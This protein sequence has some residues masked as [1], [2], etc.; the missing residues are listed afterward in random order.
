MSLNPSF[1]GFGSY[2]AQ[3]HHVTVRMLALPLTCLVLAATTPA[4]G[5]VY[6]WADENGVTHYSSAPPG[7]TKATFKRMDSEALA[8]SQAKTPKQ[9]AP[10][11][12]KEQAVQDLNSK[13]DALEHQIDAEHQARQAA[14]AQNLAT[15]AAYA[16]ALADQ[17]VQA[18]RNV[19]YVSTIPATIPVVSG[20][21]LV[22]PS[23][24]MHHDSCRSM[25]AGTMTNCSSSGHWL[26]PSQNQS[27]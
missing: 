24:R 26:R 21:L 17:Q 1:A 15:Q 7:K 23:Q 6:K 19:G 5:Q 9:E 27:H 18:A 8:V 10:L 16:Q 14:D 12:P 4:F 2:L 13:V 25:G 11:P 3:H 20:V 22:P